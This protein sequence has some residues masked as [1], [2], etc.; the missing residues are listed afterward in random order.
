MKELVSQTGGR[1]L[2]F[3]DIQDLQDSALKSA[4]SLYSGKGDFV[5]SGCDVEDNTVHAGFVFL[6]GKVRAVP[7]T[8]N[9]SFPVYIVAKN[10][11]EQGM[12]L[13]SANEQDTAIDYGV[14]FSRTNTN[15]I[16]ILQTGPEVSAGDVLFDSMILPVGLFTEMVSIEG[17]LKFSDIILQK[18]GDVLGV[19]GGMST[20]KASIPAITG[21]S[22]VL[23]TDKNGYVRVAET[24]T[25]STEDGLKVLYNGISYKRGSITKSFLL[26]NTGASLDGVLE[27]TGDVK[28]GRGTFFQADGITFSEAKIISWDQVGEKMTV[29]ASA[30]LIVAA[31]GN[32]VP[33]LTV[34]NGGAERIEISNNSIFC[35]TTS[36]STQVEPKSGLDLAGGD[37]KLYI[38]GHMYDI[39]VSPSGFIYDKNN[40]EF[41]EYSTNIKY[42]QLDDVSIINWRKSIDG[43]E[44]TGKL[45]IGLNGLYW[46]G[47]FMVE[48]QSVFKSNVVVQGQLNAPG[49]YAES[50]NIKNGNQYFVGKAG[51]YVQTTLT[52]ARFQVASGASASSSRLSIVVDKVTQTYIGGVLVNTST[53][54]GVET[55]SVTLPCLVTLN[56]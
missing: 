52:N 45:Q 54:A 30:D 11:T 34:Q 33:L 10:T 1:Y 32:T 7:E 55:S 23:G 46:D 16:K 31:S 21:T 9:L 13:D 41:S 8:S 4:L 53:Q 12:Y 29:R 49:V 28:T 24:V 39:G 40:P 5:I 14:E 25:G 44:Y 50:I 43:N 38:Q 51:Q 47:Q 22:V 20:P 42:P 18:S 36:Y 17:Q 3:E 26:S 37:A 6:E 27:V 56:T 35:R 15:G 2:F 19:T 48:Q